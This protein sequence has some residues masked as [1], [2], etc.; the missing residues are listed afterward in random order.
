MLKSYYFKVCLGLLLAER[1]IVL[2]PARYRAVGPWLLRIRRS[3]VS[4]AEP[5]LGIKRRQPAAAAA[6]HYWK[7]HGLSATDSAGNAVRRHGS[8]MMPAGSPIALAKAF[9]GPA[10]WPK[11]TAAD[12]REAVRRVER[13]ADPRPVTLGQAALDAASTPAAPEPGV[14]RTQSAQLRENA[15]SPDASERGGDRS[16]VESGSDRG[17]VRGAETEWRPAELDL[18]GLGDLSRSFW[19]LRPP[20]FEAS[21]V[22]PRPPQNRSQ[23]PPNAVGRFELLMSPSITDERLIRVP[24]MHDVRDVNQ[25]QE[26]VLG[27][28]IALDKAGRVVIATLA[29]QL[30][31]TGEITRGDEVVEVGGKRLDLR[32]DGNQAV[33]KTIRLAIASAR[34]TSTPLALLLRPTNGTPKSSSSR[35]GQGPVGQ[36]KKKK[37]AK[38]ASLAKGRSPR[39]RSNAARGGGGGGGGLTAGSSPRRSPRGSR[40]A[41]AQ[42][43]NCPWGPIAIMLP[44]LHRMLHCRLGSTCCSNHESGRQPAL[45]KLKRRL[46]NW[47][48]GSLGSGCGRRARRGDPMAARRHSVAGCRRRQSGWRRGA[49][50]VARRIG[51][52][53]GPRGSGPGRRQ[54]N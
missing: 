42:V 32:A 39:P 3:P 41:S 46:A 29:A 10:T 5:P 26:P 52:H 23:L 18:A 34:A 37:A 27:F 47:V 19:T 1:S 6:P 22:T 14:E 11:L 54:P 48:I 25:L 13:G 28:T 33:A 45:L 7:S 51:S 17:G 16:G 43:S 4:A 38:K 30:A 49:G 31:A 36:K 20:P 40:P 2:V 21:L 50:V 8:I 53:C 44:L 12:R 35:A 15:R 24:W 9:Y